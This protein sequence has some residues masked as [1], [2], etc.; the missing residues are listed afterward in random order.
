[1]ALL[2]LRSSS[3]R[4]LL[5]LA[6][7]AEA[8]MCTSRRNFLEVLI[9]F[10]SHQLLSIPANPPQ[11]PINPHTTLPSPH[12][13]VPPPS[14]KCSSNQAPQLLFSPSSFVF[15]SSARRHRLLC[16]RAGL[17]PQNKTL[18][19]ATWSVLICTQVTR[20]ICYTS[21]ATHHSPPPR[22]GQ[23]QRSLQLK[24]SSASIVQRHVLP[25]SLP[26]PSSTFL[27][28]PFSRPKTSP[29]HTSPQ[30]T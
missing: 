12:P 23:L 20:I 28:F 30:D 11:P 26:S 10:Q 6:A 17:V 4:L 8:P 24:R 7:A 2:L 16:K 3:R 1:M 18:H 14:S 27:P 21:H 29:T 9:G 22:P 13:P 5:L 19:S 25:P 15:A